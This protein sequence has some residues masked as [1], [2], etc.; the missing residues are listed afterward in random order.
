MILRAVLWPTSSVLHVVAFRGPPGTYFSGLEVVELSVS[1]AGYN[2]LL[3]FVAASFARTL[4]G[5]L[6]CL[7]TGLYGDSWFYIAEGSFTA[8]NNCNTWVA[9]AIET[10]GYPISS[11]TTITAQSVLSQLQ[12]N[13]KIQCGSA[14]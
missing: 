7:G 10:T 12:G 3:A 14:H 1:E 11:K 2:E 8:L 9:R 5:A 4:D 13:N 6:I